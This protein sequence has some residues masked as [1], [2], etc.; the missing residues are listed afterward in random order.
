MAQIREELTLLDRF[1]SS[2]TNYIGLA[3]RASGATSQAQA[4]SGAMG[5]AMSRAA[6]LAESSMKQTQAAASDMIAQT[7]GALQTGGGAI[8]LY[9][10]QIQ[11]VQQKLAQANV[12]MSLHSQRLAE[13]AAAQGAA[14]TDAVMLKN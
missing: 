2:F 12:E 5:G 14:S 13:V 8:S 4:A 3:Q 9:A 1:T 6:Q 10:G 7:S 11:S